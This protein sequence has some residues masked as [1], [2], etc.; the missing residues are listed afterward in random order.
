MMGDDDD[1]DDLEYDW[2][3]I[4]RER[5]L[6]SIID[7]I[8]RPFRRLWRFVS[9]YKADPFCADDHRVTEVSDD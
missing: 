5:V 3:F 6:F 2:L 9:G 4:L 8:V 1:L 7:P